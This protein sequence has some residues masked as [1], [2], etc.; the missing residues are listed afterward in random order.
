MKY[1]ANQEGPGYRIRQ[2]YYDYFISCC[3]CQTICTSYDLAHGTT[4]TPEITTKTGRGV[5]S[6]D[7]NA[8]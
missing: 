7:N 3:L 8:V 6:F 2:V 4:M 5:I 1:N